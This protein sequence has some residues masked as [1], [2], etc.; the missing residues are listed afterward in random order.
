M[1]YLS[2]N[3]KQN[4]YFL[5]IIII[6]LYIF[7]YFNRLF[8]LF[9]GLIIIYKLN[10]SFTYIQNLVLNEISIRKEYKIS[11][12]TIISSPLVGIVHVF[13]NLFYYKYSELLTEILFI[14]IVIVI[15][16]RK[17]DFLVVKSYLKND[18][19]DEKVKKNSNFHSILKENER[20]YN[21]ILEYLNRN[22]N[23]FISKENN[24]NEACSD[25]FI[26]SNNQSKIELNIQ[27]DGVN[28]QISLS[29][30]SIILLDVFFLVFIL[31]F[32]VLFNYRTI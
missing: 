29:C 27:K 1:E 20:L 2:V 11:I 21:P 22:D 6:T 17:Y 30:I 4:H 13:S 10:K 5:Y 8:L 12:S 28:E 25:E 31:Y 9:T 16:I 7:S 24:S 3:I 15:I 14:H 18:V 26:H 32:F 19:F 23:Y